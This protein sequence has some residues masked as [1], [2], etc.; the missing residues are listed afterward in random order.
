MTIWPFSTLKLDVWYKAFV[1]VGAPL[2]LPSLFRH[3]GITNGQVH[4][5]GAGLFFIG[6]GEWKNWKEVS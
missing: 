2:F 4:L 5:L 6:L 3:K 1:Y